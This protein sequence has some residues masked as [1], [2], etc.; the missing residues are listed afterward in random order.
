ML[1]LEI[2][3]LGFASITAEIGPDLRRLLINNSSKEI[4]VGDRLL[5]RE[6]SRIDATIFP[7]EPSSSMQGRI[8]GFLSGEAMASQL[9]TAVVDLGLRDNLAVGDVLVVQKEGPRLIDQV[10]RQ[11]MSFRDRMLA[12]FRGDRLQLP[13]EEVGTLLV[14]K[15]FEQL[16]YAVILSSLQP[17]EIANQVVSP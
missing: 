8:I 3:Y 10:E 12:I 4:R 5:I 9:D 13:G 11:R 14:Y 1:G 7:T 17:I 15:T 2:E 16:S 6:E